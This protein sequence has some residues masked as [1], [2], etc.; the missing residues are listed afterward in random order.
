MAVYFIRAEGTDFVKIGFAVSAERRLRHLQAGC[1]YRLVVVRTVTGDRQVEAAFHRMFASR[2]LD[3]EWFRWSD[4]MLSAELPSQIVNRL[5]GG[6]PALI[7]ELGGPTKVARLTGISVDAIKQMN[8]RGTVP[9]WH[10]PKFVAV[11]VPLERM[12]QCQMQRE[13]A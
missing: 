1:P 4:D 5:D 13:A 6:F 9:S 12:L 11:G 10:W 8:K 3:R 7:K 2:L